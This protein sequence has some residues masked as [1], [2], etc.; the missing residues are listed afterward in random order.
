MPP[1]GREHRHAAKN[2]KKDATFARS[3]RCPHHM[4]LVQRRPRRFN[5]VVFGVVE[6]PHGPIIAFESTTT[7][8]NVTTPA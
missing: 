6:P 8:D 3:Q 4:A 2:Q 5:R 7:V 1:L